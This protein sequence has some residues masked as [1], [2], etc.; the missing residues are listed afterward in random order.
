MTSADVWELYTLRSAV[1][2]LAAQLLAGA[3]DTA[4][5][6]KIEEAFEALA[7]A[8]KKG[9]RPGIAVADFSLHKT[10]IDLTNHSRLIAQYG[11]IEQQIRMYIRSSDALVPSSDAIIRQHR[12][13]VD[14]IIR[15]DADEAGTLS[16]QHNLTEGKKLSDHLKD[17]EV[18]QESAAKAVSVGGKKRK[19][20]LSR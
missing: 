7:R 9:D 3:I 15:G 20:P 1:E 4:A 11:L 16:E 2:R 10:I 8:C 5:S 13:I 6:A 14:A 18:A 19:A 12:P 17:L